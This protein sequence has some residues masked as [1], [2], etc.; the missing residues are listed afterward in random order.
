MKVLEEV[1]TSRF[2]LLI[3]MKR[4][5]DLIRAGRVYDAETTLRAAITVAENEDSPE[6]SAP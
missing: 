2:V 6:N 4:A 5:L 1:E 3:H